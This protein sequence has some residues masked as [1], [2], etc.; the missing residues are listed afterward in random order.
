[1][2]PHTPI[3]GLW[4]VHRPYRAPRRPPTSRFEFWRP[5]CKGA[6]HQ[7]RLALIMHDARLRYR[8]QE[9]AAGYSEQHLRVWPP[10]LPYIPSCESNTF[11]HCLPPG[12]LTFSLTSLTSNERR[13]NVAR[14]TGQEGAS[15]PAASPP[16]LFDPFIRRRLAIPKNSS[17]SAD[18]VA[19]GVKAQCIRH[20][21][22][23]S[24]GGGGGTDI[25]TT[26]GAQSCLQ[27]R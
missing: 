14:S 5:L 2:P 7:V 19:A 23:I 15:M 18:T 21:E 22:A 8:L 24:S 6:D 9:A 12:H 11:C 3:W 17:T 25:T 16:I 13:D 27:P 26:S 10:N 1:M 20:L 4:R